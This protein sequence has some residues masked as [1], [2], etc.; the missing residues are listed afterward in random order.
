LSKETEWA[1]AVSQPTP[2]TSLFNTELRIKSGYS[3]GAFS[4]FSELRAPGPFTM[5][6]FTRNGTTVPAMDKSFEVLDRGR[7]QGF[8]AEDISSAKN[9]I[10][11]SLPPQLETSQQLAAQLRNTMDFIEL[12]I[13]RQSN[14]KNSARR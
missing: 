3:Y 8:T 2:F 11:G 1:S 12:E 5:S 13:N 9:F 6:T 14:V 4:S 10:A 7:R